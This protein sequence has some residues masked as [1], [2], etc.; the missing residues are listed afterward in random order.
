[1]KATNRHKVLFALTA[2]AAL[3]ASAST[4]AA[5]KDWSKGTG[6]DWSENRN[7]K[8][9]LKFRQGDSAKFPASSSSPAVSVV[10]FDLAPGTDVNGITFAGGSW[11]IQ[12]NTMDLGGGIT[13]AGNNEVSCL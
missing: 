7:W 5:A 12:G 10:N 9:V 13:S 8:G 2:A 1:M 11:R 4:M 3:A 6:G